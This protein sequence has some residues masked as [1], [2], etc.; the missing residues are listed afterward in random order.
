MSEVVESTK[1]DIK[2]EPDPEAD[3]YLASLQ[4]DDDADDEEEDAE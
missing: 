3:L 4:P 2:A 1:P